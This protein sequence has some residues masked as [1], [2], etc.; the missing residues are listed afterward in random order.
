MRPMYKLK[1]TLSTNVTYTQ[2]ILE[3]GNKIVNYNRIS[4]CT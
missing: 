2:K 1:D 4:P 3:Y